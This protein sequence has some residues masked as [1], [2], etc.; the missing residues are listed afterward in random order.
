MG[1]VRFGVGLRSGEDLRI[2]KEFFCWGQSRACGGI[3]VRAS[4]PCPPSPKKVCFVAEA[5][6]GRGFGCGSVGTLAV[7]IEAALSCVLC[8]VCIHIHVFVAFHIFV[9]R[10]LL[11][12]ECA[13]FLSF[14]VPPLQFRVTQ[15]PIATCSLHKIPFTLFMASNYP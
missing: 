1:C 13:L 15:N 14:P 8:K 12:C 11:Y 5:L 3:W 10:Y 6:L 7:T 4:S 2:G 9:S